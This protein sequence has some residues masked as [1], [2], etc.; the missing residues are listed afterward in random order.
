MLMSILK[1]ED[2]YRGSIQKK[3]V[4]PK[5]I[6]LPLRGTSAYSTVPVTM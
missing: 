6:L 4:L 3:P 2:E 1:T 5:A